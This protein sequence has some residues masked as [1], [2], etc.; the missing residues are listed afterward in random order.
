M[1]EREDSVPYLTIQAEEIRSGDQYM[2]EE[3][4]VIWTAIDNAYLNPDEKMICVKV[5]W[6]DGAREYRYWE[7]GYSITI[8]RLD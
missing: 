6:R 5:M 2:E 7:R 3:G 1:Y 8:N 4:Y